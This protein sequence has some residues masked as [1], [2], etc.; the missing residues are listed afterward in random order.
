LQRRVAGLLAFDVA[1]LAVLIIATALF[2]EQLIAWMSS[3]FKFSVA[4]AEWGLIALAALASAPF[5]IGTLRCTRK[6]G[7]LL[8]ED[9]MPRS[10]PGQA[11]FALAPRRAMVASVQFLIFVLVGVL[12]LLVTQPFLP[13][14]P[15]AGVV[16]LLLAA[17]GFL[18]WR[19]AT[20]LQGH[21]RAGAQVLMEVLKSARSEPPSL[22]TVESLLPGL[23][24][25]ASVRVEALSPAA[26]RTL[27]ELDLQGATGCAVLAVVRKDGGTIAPSGGDVLRAGDVLALAGARDALDAAAAIVRGEDG[28]TSD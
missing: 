9:A 19:S 14:L 12:L 18:F 5:W 8:A 22:E 7:A 10:A 20:D 4:I 13:S 25:F 27:D 11:D 15:S 23:G 2:R 28:E 3:A 1:L 21:V 16:L 17:V 6:L 26:G 24:S